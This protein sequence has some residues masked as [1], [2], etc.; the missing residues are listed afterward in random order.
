MAGMSSDRSPPPDGRRPRRAKGREQD[1]KTRPEYTISSKYMQIDYIRLR[2]V[3]PVFGRVPHILPYH[4]LPFLYGP[5]R[6][7]LDPFAPL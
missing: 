3:V 6:P 4:S 7:D 5:L 1:D 2:A